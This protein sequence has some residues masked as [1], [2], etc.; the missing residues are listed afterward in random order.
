[1]EEQR[2]GSQGDVRGMGA[3]SAPEGQP[4]LNR[5]CGGR[6]LPTLLQEAMSWLCG[7]GSGGTCKE[8]PLRNGTCQF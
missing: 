3:S 5:A 6:V 4:L 7:A 2:A 8:A 1:M